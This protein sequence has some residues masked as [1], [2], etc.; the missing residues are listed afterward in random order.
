MARPGS[1][2]RIRRGEVMGASKPRDERSDSRGSHPNVVFHRT[3]PANRCAH[4]GAWRLFLAP[5]RAAGAILEGDAELGQAFANLIPEREVLRLAGFR[6]Q[7]DQQ[8]HQTADEL[9]VAPDR[10]STRLNSSH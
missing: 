3:T 7:V 9:V 4:R 5:V 2:P 1:M 10:K 8:L 6:T